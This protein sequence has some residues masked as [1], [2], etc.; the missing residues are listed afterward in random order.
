MSPL[1]L[2]AGLS[3]VRRY[4]YAA[5][6][7]GA[8]AAFAYHL[9]RVSSLEAQV[10]SAQR[11]KATAEKALSGRVAAEALTVAAAVQKARDEERDAR[12]NLQKDYDE[13]KKA[14]A[15]DG[16]QLADARQR[17]YNL[18]RKRTPACTSGRDLPPSPGPTEGADGAP[19]ELPERDQQLIDRLLR[20]G[21]QANEA[22]RQR[23][24]AV[25]QYQ[26]NCQRDK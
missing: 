6:L 26:Q 2:V 17:L 3:P 23:D 1:A 21:V 18:A 12:N 8:A 24:L 25:K 4:I 10:A 15:G 22:A 16:T 9:V 11:D 20:L 14:R 7:L 19:A 13:L 5:I